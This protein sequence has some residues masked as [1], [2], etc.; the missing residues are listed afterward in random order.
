MWR[1]KCS[2]QVSRILFLIF[3]EYSD[4]SD[5]GCGDAGCLSKRAS[6]KPFHTSSRGWCDGRTS[7]F[8][9]DVL[10]SS[11][12]L[13]A[14]IALSPYSDH[15]F[16]TFGLIFGVFAIAFD[17]RYFFANH[18][19]SIFI[20]STLF[21]MPYFFKELTSRGAAFSFQE[22][23]FEKNLFLDTCVLINC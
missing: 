15:L 1:H 11:F 5:W 7:I 23:C 12:Y 8:N 13:K 14:H 4:G 6:R 10:V 21:L 22:R 20:S 9:G 16:S 18:P 3:C 17:R 2:D 19:P